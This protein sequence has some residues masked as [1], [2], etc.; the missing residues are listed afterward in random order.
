M[1]ITTIIIRIL[2]SGEMQ[3]KSVRDRL[4]A[5]DR[6]QCDTAYLLLL[7]LVLVIS[8]SCAPGKR[9]IDWFVTGRL[10]CLCV[11]LSN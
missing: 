6:S 10:I 3:N 4:E 8:E 5:Q 9:R 2:G 7:L 1:T 11:F